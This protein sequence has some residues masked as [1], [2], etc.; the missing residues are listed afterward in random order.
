MWPSCDAAGRFKE[1]HCRAT[2]AV[3]RFSGIRRMPY[4]PG[5]W[6]VTYLIGESDESTR[7]AAGGEKL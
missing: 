1:F 6:K 5:E 7:A 4:A 3:A 2:R